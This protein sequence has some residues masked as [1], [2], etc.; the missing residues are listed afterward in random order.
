[1]FLYIVTTVVLWPI[2]SCQHRPRLR[3]LCFFLPHLDFEA[4]IDVLH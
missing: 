1:M 3:S 4:E 2:T